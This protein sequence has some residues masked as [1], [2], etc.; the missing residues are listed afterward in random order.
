[1]KLLDVTE[2]A[3]KTVK[4][5]ILSGILPPEKKKEENMIDWFLPKLL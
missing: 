3:A 5:Y 2:L 1:M 4:W